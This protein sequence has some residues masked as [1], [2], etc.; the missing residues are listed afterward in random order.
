MGH[1]LPMTWHFATSNTL[2][3]QLVSHVFSVIKKKAVYRDNLLVQLHMMKKVLNKND[4]LLME[5]CR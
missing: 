1:K 2:L 3:Y 5:I 4:L